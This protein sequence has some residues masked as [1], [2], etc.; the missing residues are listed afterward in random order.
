MFLLYRSP[1]PVGRREEFFL[2]KLRLPA[3]P[4][5][6]MQIVHATQVK[7]HTLFSNQK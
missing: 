5:D 1:I 6:E 4:T 7:K 3:A 2:F